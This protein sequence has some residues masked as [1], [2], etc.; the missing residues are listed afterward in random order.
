MAQA[1]IHHA[2]IVRKVADQALSDAVEIT[3]LIEL[4]EKQNSNG[5]NDKLNK[6]GAGRAAMVL[7]NAMIARLVT[8]VARA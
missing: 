8:I 5:I 4:I 3:V 6:A 7:R 1:P 2:D